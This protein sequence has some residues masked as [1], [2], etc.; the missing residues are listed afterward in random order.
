MLRA[1]PRHR[2]TSER[3]RLG[4]L[5]LE[6]CD[7]AARDTE[8]AGSKAHRNRHREDLIACVD[9]SKDQARCGFLRAGRCSALS[10]LGC[11]PHGMPERQR[12][13]R[14]HMQG[15]DAVQAVRKQRRQLIP[16][17]RIC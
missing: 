10:G 9:L 8:S 13:A 3:Q 16:V 14:W 1:S 12:L 2:E 11:W 4:Y 6:V 5:V 15:E 17:E 7:E